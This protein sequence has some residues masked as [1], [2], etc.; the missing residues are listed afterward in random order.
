MAVD[1]IPDLG[2]RGLPNRGDRRAA[3]PPSPREPILARLRDAGIA[4]N[5]RERAADLKRGGGSDGQLAPARRQR[6]GTPF[7]AIAAMAG[8][9]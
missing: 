4:D 9:R 6:A 7:T 1:R 3:R 2:T 8:P 5:D